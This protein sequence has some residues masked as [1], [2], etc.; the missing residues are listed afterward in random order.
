MYN[1]TNGRTTRKPGTLWHGSLS[2]SLFISGK[3]C[4]HWIVISMHL[5]YSK[6]H[7]A[8]RWD[9]EF[10]SNSTEKF[11]NSLK[12]LK[13]HEAQPSE[14]FAQIFWHLFRR[15]S[16]IEIHSTTLRNLGQASTWF[17]QGHQ[18]VSELELRQRQL[19]IGCILIATLQTYCLK[20]W[21]FCWWLQ[22]HHF[23]QRHQ[24]HVWCH[25]VMFGIAGSATRPVGTIETTSLIAGLAKP[26]G[27]L[28]LSLKIYN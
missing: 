19:C 9:L 3:K 21:D 24:W 16:L 17:Q 23:H 22:W 27:W 5:F 6:H 13:T 11:E 1:S 2:L 28:R 20:T 26:S 4:F 18:F 12:N 14:F 7:A 15:P 8:E 10:G 25:I